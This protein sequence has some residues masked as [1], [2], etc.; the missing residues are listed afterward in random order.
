LL[1]AMK[2]RLGN[3][4]TAF[5]LISA[6]SLDLVL[7][8]LKNVS[9]PLNGQHSWYV[10][11]ELSSGGAQ[12]ALDQALQEA[13]EEGMESDWVED[14]ALAAAASHAMDFWRIREEISDA[15]T[16]EGG[17]VRCDI[18][19]PLSNIPRFIEL[20]TERVAETE[21]TSRVIAYGHMGDGNVHFNPLRP[22]GISGEQFVSRHGQAIGSAVNGIA[23]GL[24]GSISAEHGV[25]SA[26]R[27]ELLT[28]K[29]AVEL[30]LYWRIKSA[31]DPKGLMNPG[32]MLP[33]Q[34][35][36]ERVAA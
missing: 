16:H 18:S 27:D 29:S 30:D 33:A 8:Y 19:V 15:Q 17:S 1:S 5:E 21:P 23:T 24:R 9:S 12:E 6:A 28:V 2:R 25:G 26:K 31:L 34:H 22:E 32:K 13:L 3:V 10:L 7:H 35:R 36:I 20:A 11:V 14:A 4:V